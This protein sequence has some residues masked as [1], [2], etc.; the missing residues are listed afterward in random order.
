MANNNRGPRSLLDIASEKAAK[1]VHNKNTR[2]LSRIPEGVREVLYASRHVRSKNVRTLARAGNAAAATAARRRRNAR[3][4]PIPS[5]R[6]PSAAS[7]DRG[8]R[9]LLH[10]TH[11]NFDKNG[12]WNASQKTYRA[13]RPMATRGGRWREHEI[14]DRH[15]PFFRSVWW[16]TADAKRPRWM[17]PDKAKR[18]ANARRLALE[19]ISNRNI[20]RWHH[21]CT[22]KADEL[23]EHLYN[24]SSRAFRNRNH[25]TG[26]R[27]HRE[28]KALRKK[29]LRE[30]LESAPFWNRLKKSRQLDLNASRALYM[31]WPLGKA[32][33]KNLLETSD[34][35]SNRNFSASNSSNNNRSNN[36]ITQSEIDNLLSD[37]RQLL[38]NGNS[39][40]FGRRKRQRLR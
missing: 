35:N 5:L 18:N 6:G 24:A 33:M 22:E 15:H 7:F 17:A 40:N 13:P 34:S 19:P 38:R 20:A 32:S 23:S 4:L 2:S 3:P 8:Y 11:R 37:R 14:P 25:A 12:R 9:D 16:K 28:A 26:E 10:V 27:L 29:T 39:A 31:G 1:H 30:C 36:S 21:K